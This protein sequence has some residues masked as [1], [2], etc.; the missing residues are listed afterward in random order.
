MVNKLESQLIEQ[1]E[2]CPIEFQNEFR[3]VYQQLKVVDK[4]M[5]IK[6]VSKNKLNEKEI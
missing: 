2:K 3:K 1:L 6:G 5:E 4:P